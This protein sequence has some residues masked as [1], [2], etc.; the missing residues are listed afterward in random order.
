MARQ[1]MKVLIPAVAAACAVVLAACSS[2]ATS[3]SGNGS[4]ASS[5][6]STSGG[7]VVKLM[8]IGPFSGS[9]AYNFPGIPKVLSAYFNQLNAAGGINGHKV[10]ITYCSD[11]VDPNTA[12]ACANEA[13][14]DG[15]AAVLSTS[16]L[17]EA[18]D[19]ILEAHKISWIGH[20]IESQADGTS[21]YSFPATAATAEWGTV[22]GKSLAGNGCKTVASMYVNAP[23]VQLVFNKAEQALTAAG[24]G[25]LPQSLQFQVTASDVSFLPQV[26]Q[27]VNSNA[28]CLLGL[29]TP[30]QVTVVENGI[31]TSSRP[32]LP[33]MTYC[34][35]VTPDVATLMG[36]NGNGYVACG[37]RLPGEEAKYPVLTQVKQIAGSDYNQSTILAWATADIAAAAI[38]QIT[39]P[40]TADSMHT[41]LGNLTDVSTGGIL[42][43]YTTS[44]A[45]AVV[46][47]YT[48]VFNPVVNMWKFG[49]SGSPVLQE[50]VNAAN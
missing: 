24:A 20:A 19:P 29:L 38:K 40:V 44:K 12:A 50:S 46:D 26:T 31:A 47:G 16:A 41:A 49:S 23:T 48:R 10:D 22:M 11:K 39:G 36:K 25:G 27:V 6:G 33:L 17:T 4:N 35:S 21:N 18:F 7:D 43:P 32:T 37:G 13:V 2:S 30:A 9:T 42:P 28:G 45:P 1:A 5:A 34:Q 3:S 14:S 8:A 15:V